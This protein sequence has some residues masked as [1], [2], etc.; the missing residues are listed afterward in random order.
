M[1]NKLEISSVR[2]LYGDRLILSDVYLKIETGNIIGLLGRNGE[3]K[4]SLMRV[5]YGTI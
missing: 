5:I 3:G 4:S 2:L 1:K